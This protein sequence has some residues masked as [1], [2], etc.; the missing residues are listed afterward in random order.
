[1]ATKASTMIE[2]L[3]KRKEIET[4]LTNLSIQKIDEPITRA[5]DL[6]NSS[7]EKNTT[8]AQPIGISKSVPSE[9]KMGGKLEAI[10]LAPNKTN[11]YNFN[12]ADSQY[13][14]VVL[15]KVDAIFASEAKNA[16]N[17]FNRETTSNQ[18]IVLNTMPLNGQYQFI[19]MGPFINAADAIG[20]ISKTKPFAKSRIIPWLS[21]EKYSFT[22]ISNKNLTKLIDTK[23]IPA[24][25][26]FI[27][28]IF[29]DVF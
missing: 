13:V 25:Q 14:V 6:N 23:D 19:M 26:K 4:Y 11:G 12:A 10:G 17:R 20:Y 7:A 27:R 1:M 21:A 9:L 2:V 5:V 15:D 28:E 24:Y 8:T 16:F 29:S 18:N 3:N 22:I